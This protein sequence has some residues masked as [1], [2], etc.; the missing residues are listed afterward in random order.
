MTSMETI[1]ALKKA[2]KPLSSTTSLVN[3]PNLKFKSGKRTV[4]TRK[5]YELRLEGVS[6]ST[7]SNL[8]ETKEKAKQALA[9]YFIKFV[10]D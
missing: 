6:T 4:L 9:T 2:V 7:H 8:T 3:I 10:K 1:N 5:D